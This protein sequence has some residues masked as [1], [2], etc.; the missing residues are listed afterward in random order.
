MKKLADLIQNLDYKLVQ[1]D[2]DNREVE[3]IVY[4]SR[5]VFHGCLL[6]V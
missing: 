2:L 3:G 5:K 6:Y 4:D 1:G